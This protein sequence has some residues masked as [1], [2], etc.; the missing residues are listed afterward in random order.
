M[1]SIFGGK[2]SQSTDTSSNQ[3]YGLLRD[4]LSPA[5]SYLGEGASGISRLL[6]G[7]ASGFNAFKQ[8][9]GFDQA[10]QAGSRGITGNAAAGGLLRS[11]ST[12]KALGNYTNQMQNQYATNYLQNLLGLSGI[13]AQAGQIISGAGATREAK[14]SSKEK[15]GLGG[16]IGQ[17]A[18]GMAASDRR[19]KKNIE[20]VGEYSDGLNIYDFEYTYKPGKY[21]GVMADEVEKLR[22]WALGP[23]FDGFKTVDYS[24]LER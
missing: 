3:A 10:L 22:P 23:E 1:S 14:S 11:G 13:G 6:G 5:L 18:S 12:G 9:T 17:A 24:K 21:R 4:S 20:K 19:L 7:D 15:P 8:A 2:K 16:F